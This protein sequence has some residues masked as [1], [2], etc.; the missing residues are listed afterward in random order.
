TERLC[1]KAR[2]DGARA[3]LEAAG[4][5]LPARRLRFGHWFSFEDGLSLGQELLR[6]NPTPTAIVCGNDLQ[7]LGV[8]EAARLAGRRIPQ[9]LSVVGFDDITNNLDCGPPMTSVRQPLTEM[10]AAATRMVLTLAAN[11]NLTQTRVELATTL[12]VRGSTAAAPAH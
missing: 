8:Y 7:A 5:G 6:Q 11:E 4:A 3:A 1:A 9:D 10:A 2:L 12:V